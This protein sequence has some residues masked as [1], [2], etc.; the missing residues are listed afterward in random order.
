LR[1]ME[2]S[3]AEIRLDIVTGSVPSHISLGET[4]D[5]A[6]ACVASLPRIGNNAGNVTILSSEREGATCRRAFGFC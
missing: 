1:M 4:L 6:Q 2:R 5:E 3:R